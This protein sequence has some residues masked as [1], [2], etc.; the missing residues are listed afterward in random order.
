[1]SSLAKFGGPD[2]DTSVEF[3]HPNV[4][5]REEHPGWSRLA[6]GAREREIPLILELCRDMSGP[7]GI[8]YVLIVSRRG[9][10]P[11]RYQSPEPIAYDALERFLH[12]FREFLEQDGR[13]HLWVTSLSDEGQFV[14]DRHNMVYAY[15]DLDR[16]ESHLD[17]AGFV[18]G[19]VAIPFP[20]SHHY[21]TEFDTAE[22]ELMEYWRWKKFP[23]EPDDN[24]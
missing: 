1:L 9:R 11:G 22:D 24:P 19:Q 14:F 3:A 2:R 18:R 13:H 8:L 21:H 12:T 23:L 5:H 16:Y 4:W 10:D 20:H 17:S 7:F 15:G 6:I